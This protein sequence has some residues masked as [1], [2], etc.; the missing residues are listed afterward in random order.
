MIRAGRSIEPAPF[1]QY[2]SKKLLKRG[3][4]FSDKEVAIPEALIGY[5]P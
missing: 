2:A 3:T 1:I 4:Y 5:F